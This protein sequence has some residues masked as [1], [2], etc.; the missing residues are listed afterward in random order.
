MINTFREATARFANDNKWD[1]IAH[2]LKVEGR[3]VVTRSADTSDGYQDD[4]LAK[5]NDHWNILRV[6][7]CTD[8][9]K[10][11]YTMGGWMYNEPITTEDLFRKLMRC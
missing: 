11:C 6:F 4:H 9:D 7:Y 10:D 2:K 3:T 5:I 1:S 8:I